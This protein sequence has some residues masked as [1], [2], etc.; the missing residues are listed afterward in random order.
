[1]IR[2]FEMIITFILVF[3]GVLVLGAG[4]IGVWVAF[5]HVGLAALGV[6]AFA[7][8]LA[9]AAAERRGDEVQRETARKVQP[10]VARE[11][12]REVSRKEPRLEVPRCPRNSTTNDD[13]SATIIQ[14]RVPA[15]QPKER[16]PRLFRDPDDFTVIERTEDRR[17]EPWRS[18]PTR[19]DAVSRQAAS[20]SRCS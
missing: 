1:M 8:S 18:T 11:V 2:I 4:G 17:S 5:G 7:V 20:A 15:R 13:G 19:G 10:Q 14:W 16:E 3:V 12:S 9:W 6:V